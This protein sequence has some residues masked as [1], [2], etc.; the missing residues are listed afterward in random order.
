MKPAS[1][2]AKG[3]R[4]QVWVCEQISKTIGL[5][6]GKDEDIASREMGQSGADVRLSRIARKFFPFSVECKNQQNWAIPKWIEQAKQNQYDN[7]N[8]LLFVSKNHYKPIVIL[9]ARLFFAI[10]KR[11]FDYEKKYHDRKN[12][13]KRV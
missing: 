2:K 9:D 5:K 6:F 1:G 11:L 12:K 4:L 3:R 13:H 7:T 10:Y 8:W